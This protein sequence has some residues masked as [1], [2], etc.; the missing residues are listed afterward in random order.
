MNQSISTT[1]SQSS[2]RLDTCTVVPTPEFVT[3]R[4]MPRSRWLIGDS[5]RNFRSQ[6]SIHFDHK[7]GGSEIGQSLPDPIVPTIDIDGDHIRFHPIQH[8]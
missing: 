7:D 3:K 5:D 8:L 4:I 2:H 6:G 1:L